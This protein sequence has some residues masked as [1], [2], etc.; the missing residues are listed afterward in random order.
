[1]NSSQSIILIATQV[2]I[3]EIFSKWPKKPKTHPIRMISKQSED[4]KIL[5]SYH[6]IHFAIYEPIG[7]FE[8][9]CYFLWLNIPIGV[10][11]YN[12]INFLYILLHNE[13]LTKIF[14]ELHVYEPENDKE[15]ILVKYNSRS[16]GLSFYTARHSSIF[17]FFYNMTV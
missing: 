3:L 5:L 14:N 11:T 17:T 16:K 9:P 12:S 1:M 13:R 8:M 10:L 4:Q 2:I 15:A 6:S 7:R